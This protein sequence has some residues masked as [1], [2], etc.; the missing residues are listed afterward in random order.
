MEQIIYFLLSHLYI[1]SLCVD[2]SVAT[3][4][5][6]VQFIIYPS[7][8]FIV[9]VKF[10]RFHKNY[11]K[12]ITYFIFPLILI[13]FS[14]HLFNFFSHLSI[15]NFLILGL[16]LLSL[17]ITLFYAIPLHRSLNV[18]GNRRDLVSSLIHFNAIRTA[19]WFL[20][21]C[22]NFFKSFII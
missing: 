2:V 20:L 17:I 14:I 5:V 6:L 10:H 21:F 15:L 7:F 4:L 12:S 9:P 22:I 3:I 19:A 11:M 16:L 1:I 18:I 13:Q 8:H